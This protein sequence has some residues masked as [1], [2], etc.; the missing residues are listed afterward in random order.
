MRYKQHTLTKLDAQVT[1]LRTI[2]RALSN[3]DITAAAVIERLE[4]VCKELELI[5]ERLN[6]EPNE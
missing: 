2:Q 1:K 4:I 3:S 5:S 6:L